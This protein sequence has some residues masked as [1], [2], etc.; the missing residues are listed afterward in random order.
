[1]KWSLVLV[2]TFLILLFSGVRLA[3]PDPLKAIRFSYFDTLQQTHPRQWQDLPVRV[4][5]LDEASLAQYGQWPWPRST[6]AQLTNQLHGYGATVVA[7][8]VLFAEADR[9]SPNRLLEVPGLSDLVALPQDA[10]VLAALDNDT[11]FAQALAQMP[12]VLG[13]AAGEVSGGEGAIFDKAGFVSI[14]NA[15]LASATSI[16]QT[17]PIVASLAHAASGIGNIN[18]SPLDASSTARR[19]PLVW[20]SAD[21]PVPTLSL[22]ALRLALGETT[23]IARGIADVD[24]AMQSLQLGGYI[25]PTT[26]SGEFWVHF[27]RDDPRLY[28][29]AA[30]VL[31]SGFEPAIAAQL[32]GNLV[33]IGTSAAGLQDIRTTALGERVPGV[34]VH[35]QILE[36]ILTERYL[37]RSDITAALEILAYIV[38]GVSLVVV[39]SFFGPLAAVATVS[40]GAATI[41]A[42]SHAYFA[43]QGHLVDASFPL[44]AGI[45][46]Y[47]ILT[48]YQF[49][50]ADQEKRKLRHSFSQYLSP[51]VLAQV[52][53]RGYKE[54]LGG[55]MRPVT[56]MFSDIRNFTELGEQLTPPELVSLLNEL[57][58]TLTEQI[59]N[60]DGT[61]DKYIGD[62]VMAFWN[63]PLT[64]ERHALAAAR[65]ALDMRQALKE[66]SADRE[67]LG[68]TIEL[69]TG[70][71]MGDVLVGNIGSKQ[72]FNYSVIGDTVNV[73]ARTEAACRP[74][75]FDIVATAA[76]RDVAGDLAWIDAG[77]LE[78]KGKSAPVPFYILVG[79]ERTAVS[80]EFAQLSLTHETLI[81][82][83]KTG[84]DLESPL[85]ECRKRAERVDP[86]LLEF[87]DKMPKRWGD[88][89]G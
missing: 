3:D 67:D 89:G 13:L 18:L 43:S 57:F 11:L 72:R 85:A 31:S 71:A 28:V 34:S 74:I 47:G 59:L 9:Y 24:G 53:R 37:N 27:R 40:V 52:E 4:V 2:G 83:I 26:S 45:L 6:L 15:P 58:T 10:E 30:D 1:M 20:Q 5:D 78:I 68:K 42:T 75:G 33:L 50:V 44:L 69:A 39:M 84:E 16:R 80:Q 62:N 49:F 56:I 14:G 86:R 70:L 38:F 87:Y 81:R 66:F 55:E 64:I 77:S 21:G 32:Q 76:V 46:T 7:F 12:T 48:A 60:N 25:I 17:T 22:E 54:E 19:V 23:Y 63:A 41:L 36:Q 82:S 73:A 29:S 8:D 79:D 51:T 65:A 88:Y 61:I 35:A